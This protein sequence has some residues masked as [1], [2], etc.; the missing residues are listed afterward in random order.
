VL[1]SATQLALETRDPE[2]WRLKYVHGITP[3]D[4]FAAAGGGAFRPP[5]P[6]GAESGGELEGKLRGSIVHGALQRAGDDPGELEDLL[7]ELL[8]EEIGGIDEEQVAPPARLRVWR[9]REQLRSEIER[10]LASD[11]W[12]EWVS[13][14]HFR[15]LPFVH[16]AGPS[17]WRQGRID[18]FVPARPRSSADRASP[19][20]VDFKTDRVAGEA[21]GQAAERHR[22]Q[23]QLYREAVDA[24]LRVPGSA[25]GPAGRTRVILHFT[26]AGRQVEL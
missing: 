12:K 22:P 3:A 15:E 14:L 20:I 24:I 10:L 25:A 21:V 19:L 1:R 7:D 11:T 8:E 23:A 18:L 5:M 2:A 9:A 16:F 4:S 13:G 6:E 26:H 17:D